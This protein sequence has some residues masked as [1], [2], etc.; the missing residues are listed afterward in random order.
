MDAL[1]HELAELRAATEAEVLSTRASAAADIQHAQETATSAAARGTATETAGKEKSMVRV[2]IERFGNQ[3]VTNQIV[4]GFVHDT[5]RDR[6]RRG[7][8]PKS[9]WTRAAHPS[10]SARPPETAR[11]QRRPSYGS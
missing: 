5:R 2:H 10:S 11:R 1:E 9:T 3:Q 4:H 6:S 8:C 7:R